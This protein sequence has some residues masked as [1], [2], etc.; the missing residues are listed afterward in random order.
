MPST[1]PTQQPPSPFKGFDRQLIGGTWRHGRAQGIY[2]NMNPRENSGIGRFNGRWAIDAFTTDQWVTVQHTPRRFPA[3]AR[4]LG[5]GVERGIMACSRCPRRVIFSDDPCAG[6]TNPSTFPAT[7]GS[8]F[9]HPRDIAVHPG[10]QKLPA[11]RSDVAGLIKQPLLDKNK[12]LGLT[13][14]RYVQVC[15][16]VA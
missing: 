12:G 1:T 11:A 13:E 7:R 14:R 8:V 10:L 15:Q 9:F 3:D 6:I 5:G 2:K 16:H 4:Q